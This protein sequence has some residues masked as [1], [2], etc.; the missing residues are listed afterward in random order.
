MVGLRGCHL[1][2]YEHWNDMLYSDGLM[3]VDEKTDT[4]VKY[5]IR[6]DGLYIDFQACG[7]K[8]D[9]K[10]M[11][12]FWKQYDPL[13]EMRVHAGLRKK[14]R[15]IL[16][17]IRDLYLAH[18]DRPFIIR[19]YSQGGGMAILVGAY[20]RMRG[21]DTD[22]SVIAFAP[23]RVSDKCIMF[24]KFIAVKNNGDIVTHLPPKLFGYKDIAWNYVI[25]ANEKR[26]ILPKYHEDRVYAEGL[27]SMYEG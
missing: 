17:F 15:G 26:C 25:N 19:G 2:Y 24:S 18:H 4:E 3:W 21:W 12:H 13:L 7:S 22:V 23:P 14:F 5:S 20:L 10:L 11:F 6:D 8:I 9:W 1:N 16:E 27:R